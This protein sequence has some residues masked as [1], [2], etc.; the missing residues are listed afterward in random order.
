[1]ITENAVFS[2]MVTIDAS[3]ETVWAILIDFK[4]Y[5]KWNSFCP[6]IQAELTIGSDVDMQVDLGNGLQQQIEQMVRIEP[7]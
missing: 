4:N 5:K 7:L 3:V 6:S 1:M 2:D